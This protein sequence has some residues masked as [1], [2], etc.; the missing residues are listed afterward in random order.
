MPD[1][2]RMLTAIAKILAKVEALD[3][4][5]PG[6]SEVTTQAFELIWSVDKLTKDDILS[7][8]SALLKEQKPTQRKHLARL[9]TDFIKAVELGLDD[10]TYSIPRQ[11][12]QQ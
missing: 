11:E 9:V 4:K 6:F 5:F 1:S 7:Q 10:G 2:P 8:I 12:T 3:A